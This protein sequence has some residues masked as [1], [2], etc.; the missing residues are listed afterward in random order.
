MKW[1]DV[2]WYKCQDMDPRKLEYVL[3][4]EDCQSSIFKPFSVLMSTVNIKK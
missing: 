1:C 2:T 4:R 3:L